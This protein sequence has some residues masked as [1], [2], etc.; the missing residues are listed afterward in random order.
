MLNVAVDAWHTSDGSKATV[1]AS[2]LVTG[3]GAG[4]A[5]ITATITSPAVTSNSIAVTVQSQVDTTPASISIS[6]TTASIAAG[7]TQQ[8][9]NAVKNA[10]NAVLSTT[11]SAWQSSSPS[12]ATVN[13][14]GLVTGVAPGTTNITATL[15]SPALTSNTAAVTVTQPIITG[16]TNLAR[17]N[18]E[19]GTFGPFYNAWAG[20]GGV[21]DIID[22]PTGGG[23]GK[24]A[25]MQY[26]NNP[27]GQYDSN[28]G[29]Y[30]SNDIPLT[31]GQSRWIQGDFYI[32]HPPAGT[33]LQQRKLLVDYGQ[34]SSGDGGLVTSW[35]QDGDPSHSQLNFA[36]GSGGA[37][38]PL[39][40]V[41]GLATFSWDAWHRLKVHYTIE[42]S[43]GATNGAAVIY[44]DGAAVG[45]FTGLT[46]IA[47]GFTQIGG[48]G[49]GYQYNS[50]IQSTEFRYWD[51]LSMADAESA[52]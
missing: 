12:I 31:F 39:Y 30:L 10:A 5:T 34:P 36:F 33:E 38:A 47:P 35:G 27:P 21:I 24:I 26:S 13:S 52:L 32:P 49:F 44:F 51:N 29:L 1:S 15:T 23:H 14:S 46:W 25:R 20:V 45:T 43:Q 28:L 8:M 7:A 50:V 48:P 2:G 42:T 16:G 3:A 4:S 11:P 22:D 41:Y 19:D 40:T 37:K 17:C 6:P 18:F 9:S